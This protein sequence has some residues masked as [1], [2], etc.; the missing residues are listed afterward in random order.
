MKRRQVVKGG[1]AG[2]VGAV[3]GCH[4]RGT[5]IP[6]VDPSIGGDNRPETLTVCVPIRAG[7]LAEVH[8]RLEEHAFETP[9]AGVHYARMLV[10]PGG[11]L[12]LAAVFDNTREALL[13]LMER[14]AERV[15]RVLSLTEGYPAAGAAARFELD[16][17]MKQRAL[18]NMLL[19]SAFSNGSELAMR[20]AT[21][22]RREFLT[23]VQS[24]VRDPAAAEHAYS[25][26]LAN[27]RSRIDTHQ[28]EAVDQ[29]TPTQLTAPDRQN[30]FTMIF[31]IRKDWVKRLKDTLAIGQW[32]IENF[33]IHPL[34]Q[35]PTVH[36]A[37]FDKLS[38]TRILFS[39]IY[40]GEWE[41][42]VS[43]F[44]VHIP[45]KLDK[46]WGGAVGYPKG[47]A[48]DAPALQKF[49]EDH[50]IE[51]DYFFSSQA[52]ATVKDLQASLALGKKLVRFSKDAPS[53]AARLVKHIDRFV[54]EHQTLLA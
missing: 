50:R 13:Q 28:D 16:A 5:T 54:R 4:R 45:G 3:A 1:L 34:K 24:T 15:D 53:D 26:F 46:V 44:A 32:A 12:V 38:D 48:A 27:N 37:R 2:A 41:Q 47:G 25:V 31:D 6:D 10:I 11:H 42:Y 35:I 36:Y 20:E 9:S 22:L 30:P 51:R 19:Y 23:L 18:P 14:N 43:D 8:A 33:H 17:W 7:Q 39:S 52:G 21:K 29:L 49:L 40:D